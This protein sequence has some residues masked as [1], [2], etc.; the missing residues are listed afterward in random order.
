MRRLCRLPLLL[1]AACSSAVLAQTPDFSGRW[2]L[3]PDPAAAG[4]GTGGGLG[5]SVVIRQDAASL[6]I[7]R[8]TPAGEITS[9]LKLD[10]SESKNIANIQG[11]AIEQL[12]KARWDGATLRIE[13]TMAVDG[14]SIQISSAFSLD[15]SGNLVVVSTRPDFQGGSTP[16]TTKNTYK[17]AE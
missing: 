3:V 7:V 16:I 17:K 6:T 4:G 14:N 2:T 15:A 1:A 13:T 5:Q 8:T 9:I 10:G 12:S 11:S